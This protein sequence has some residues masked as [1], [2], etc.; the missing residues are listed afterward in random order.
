V[1]ALVPLFVAAGLLGQQ[2]KP[3]VFE[4]QV[5]TVHV[6]V[7]VTRGGGA[8]L[9][10]EA[11]D[12]ELKDNGVVQKIELAAAGSQPLV[13]V[14]TFDTSGSLA[15]EKLRAL[16]A[17]S[18]AFMA[19][20][21]PED[22]VALFTFADVIDWWIP[23]TR[24]RARVT[25]ALQRAKVGGATA[26]LDAL[27]AALTLP[28]TKAR[29]LVVL[30]TDGEDNMSWLDWRDVQQVAQRSNALLHVVSLKQPGGWAMCEIAEVTGGRCWQAASL[31]RLKDA[32]AEIAETMS[33]RY[34]L[35]YE[36]QG[37]KRPG[38]HKLEV[39]LKSKRGDIQGRPGYWV[40]ER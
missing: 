29:S 12:F 17:A 30:F 23:P 6:D 33:R 4:V 32:F 14:L 36:P 35:R 9:G 27:F 19:A 18:Q 16:R 10:L 39:R 11:S 28:R 38:W 40:A 1:R 26:V 5:E 22:E 34:V 25:A 15:G 8:V 13:A 31:E 21:R 3:P 24:D 7:F 20:L 37:T 2:P